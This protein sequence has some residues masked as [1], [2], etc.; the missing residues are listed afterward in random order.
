MTKI[1]VIILAAGKGQ[2]MQSNIPKV[3]HHLGGKTLL[4]HVVETALHSLHAQQVYIVYGHNGDEIRNQL[5]SL[6][7]TWVEQLE[8][9]GTAHAVSQPLPQIPDDHLIIV[10]YGDVPL[11]SPQTL[12][13]L[14]K[15]T[16]QKGLCLLVASLENPTGLGRIIRDEHGLFLNIVEEKD[17]TQIERNIQEIFSGILAIQA[18]LLKQYIQKVGRNNAQKE[19]YLTEVPT[20]ALREGA[21]V[22]TLEGKPE[23]VLGV[24][25]KEQLALMER[26]YQRREANHLLQQGAILKDLHRV[27]VRGQ[28]EVG[29]DTVID[30]NVLFEGKVRIGRDTYIGPHVC[31]KDCVIGNGVT[32][33][34]HSVI[35]G[36]KVGDEVIIGPFARLRPDTELESH[37]HVGNFVE[38]KKSMVKE[39]SKINHLAYVGDSHVGRDV[40][41]GAGVITCNYDGVNKHETIIED[42]AF[43]GSNV[44]LVAPL[45]IEKGATIGAGST[46]TK[47]A[48]KDSLT[49]GR[50]RQSTIE[51]WQ[52]PE[53]NKD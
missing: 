12:E 32:I 39:G 3:L 41:I 33:K 47:N 26:L 7:V 52:R 21:M 15:A 4:E 25:D 37:V 18:G 28:V 17:A 23:E 36:A 46:V 49:L 9:L 50:A 29:Q 14:V 51:R 38:I 42:K 30:I 27:D 22:T 20:I 10:L 2:R 6:P 11:I 53:K 8:Q 40:N 13:A 34:A 16:P 44:S 31:L 19:Y 45:T 5:S 35:D 24:N 48:P 1:S 43:I